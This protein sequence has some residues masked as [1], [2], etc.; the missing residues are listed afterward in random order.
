MRRVRTFY[1]KYPFL[2]GGSMVLWLWSGTK[3]CL[4]WSCIDVSLVWIKVSRGIVPFS[5]M[6]IDSA[7]QCSG[8]MTFW[9]G[10]GPGSADPCLWT[11]FQIHD[12]FVWIRKIKS[13]KESLK[14]RI[15]GFSYYFCMMIEGS[16]SRAGSGSIPLT[17]GSG[18][19]RPKK[20]VDPVDPDSERTRPINDNGL[21]RILIRRGGRSFS[22]WQLRSWTG[23]RGARMTWSRGGSWTRWS[24]PGTFQSPWGQYR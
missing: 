16:G 15:Q 19:G 8:S 24:S 12:I 2:L 3:A 5:P 6:G 9:C 14:S 17:S 7:N 23:W 4:F 13:Q 20:H 1:I 21:M 11:V 18:S 10:S 22:D